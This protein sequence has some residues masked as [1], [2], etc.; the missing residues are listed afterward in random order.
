MAEPRARRSAALVFDGIYDELLGVGL[1]L[2]LVVSLKSKN[3]TL[4][5]AM[6]TVKSST[7]GFSVSLF[8]QCEPKD[9][10]VDRHSNVLKPKK[11]KRKRKSRARDTTS[12]Q[13]NKSP[14]PK[15]LVTILPSKSAE[16]KSPTKSTPK[17]LVPS[18][19]AVVMTPAK[20]NIALPPDTPSTSVILSGKKENE[21]D[22]ENEDLAVL[23]KVFHTGQH[24]SE[25][26]EYVCS[27]EIGPALKFE[28]KR[29]MC[30][31]PIRL[32]GI[33]DDDDCEE[34][35]EETSTA[36]YLQS[37]KGIEY[38]RVNGKP[39]LNLHRGRCRFWTAIS[40]TPEVARLNLDRNND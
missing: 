13:L 4:E 31:T 38:V 33:E 35:G 2:P 8:W 28:T 30:L 1:P 16:P 22:E 40:V 37:C 32:V 19:A 23:D 24:V 34:Q 5:S 12:T 27:D 21:N 25:E 39:G 14:P 29:G 15:D 3:L 10:T 36:K 20:Q 26:T 11:K 17:P 6:W 9:V 18:D 7:T